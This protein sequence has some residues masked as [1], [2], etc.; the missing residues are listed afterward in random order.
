MTRGLYPSKADEYR[1]RTQAT[2]DHFSG[3]KPTSTTKIKG[4]KTLN[5]YDR[6]P[7]DLLAGATSSVGGRRGTIYMEF[8][9]KAKHAENTK[10][11]E[12]AHATPH[13]ASWRSFEMIHNPGQAMREENRAYTAGAGMKQDPRFILKAKPG[14]FSR[15]I[16]KPLPPRSMRRRFLTGFDRGMNRT[17]TQKN[18]EPALMMPNDTVS[19]SYI[20]GKGFLKAVDVGTKDLKRARFDRF[21]AGRQKAAKGASD[22]WG[23]LDSKINKAPSP[24][25]A[26]ALSGVSKMSP[27][28]SEMH[29]PGSTFTQKPQIGNKGLRRDKHRIKRTYEAGRRHGLFW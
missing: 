29:V 3:V 22:Y 16:A 12:M 26:S 8:E 14:I 27:D 25:K 13:R 7:G 11:H 6:S 15:A 2:R 5:Y 21:S 9:S 28:S 24:V 19:K 18:M 1:G 17:T 4:G 20:P 23:N 10:R